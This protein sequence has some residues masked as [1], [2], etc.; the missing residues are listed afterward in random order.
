[1]DLGL[2]DK[3]AVVTGGTSGIGLATAH[4]L[5]AEGALVAICGRDEARLAAAEA[6]LLGNASDKRLLAVRCDVL[7]K[8]AVGRFAAAVEQWVGRCDVL[9]NNAGQARMSTFADT[10]DEA[11]REELEL[12]FFSQI[13]PIRA[14]KPLLDKSNAAAILS[15]NSLLAY[16][17]EPYMVATAAARAGA[18]SLLKSLARE[19]APRIR[20]NSVMLG[21]IDSG[22][23]ERRFVVREDKT[24]TREQW[25]A[26]VARTRHIP[27][28]RLGTSAEVARAVVFLCSPAAGFITGAQL[29][30]SGGTSRHI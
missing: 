11:W 23:W 25:F 5:L 17:P 21:L 22:Q 8:A 30:I 7:D 18:Q 24:Q 15:V 16:Q 14:F 6:S 27:L 28:E 12:K 3:V 10:S 9:I 2:Q 20:V 13:Y 19:F 1:M 29:E 26:E 4:Q